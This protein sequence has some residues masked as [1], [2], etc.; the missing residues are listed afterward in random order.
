MPNKFQFGSAQELAFLYPAALS[1]KP[2]LYLFQFR[3]ILLARCPPLH[4]K[5]SWARLPAIMREAQKVERLWLLVSA[6]SAL[7]G[8][9]AE[10]QQLRLTWLYLQVKLRQPCLHL[11]EEPFG[12]LSILKAGQEVIRKSK[13]IGFPTARPLEPLLEPEIERVMQVHV[14]QK[15]R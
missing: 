6:P 13:V 14:G 2:F 8:K 12:I 11:F 7:F 9:P 4:L 1:L 3:A 5:A 10:L 15:R